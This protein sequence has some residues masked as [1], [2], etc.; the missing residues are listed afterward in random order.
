VDD[1]V[2]VGVSVLVAVAMGV[3]VGFGVTLGVDLGAWVGAT[4]GLEAMVLV[5][6]GATTG[7]IV[8]GVGAASGRKPSPRV[9]YEVSSSARPS[10]SATGRSHVRK[11]RLGAMSSEFAGIFWLGEAT[12]GSDRDMDGAVTAD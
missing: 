8:V 4:V 6:D 5:G 9:A 1:G 10:M 12:D 7:M 11:V 2:A 3:A